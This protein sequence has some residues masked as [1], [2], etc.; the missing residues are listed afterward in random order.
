[1]LAVSE[2][3]WAT[4]VWKS[5]SRRLETT[6][7]ASMAMVFGLRNT[8]ERRHGPT[9]HCQNPACVVSAWLVFQETVF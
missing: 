1:M 6:L 7:L 5:S 4:A 9:K 2:Q 3:N 8:K